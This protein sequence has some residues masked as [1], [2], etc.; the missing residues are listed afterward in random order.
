MPVAEEKSVVE[1]QTSY[2]FFKDIPDLVSRKFWLVEQH[3]GLRKLEV[4]PRVG[5]TSG[6]S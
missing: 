3:S 6:A 2:A 4:A 1:E 5:G